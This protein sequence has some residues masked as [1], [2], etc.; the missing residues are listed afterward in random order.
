[1][2][3]LCRKKDPK[4]ATVPKDSKAEVKIKTKIIFT[5]ESNMVTML[6]SLSL[7]AS[8]NKFFSRI[9]GYQNRVPFA[10]VM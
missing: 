2:G 4:I 6:I 9:V 7:K 10:L 5:I 3:A 8:L 1:M